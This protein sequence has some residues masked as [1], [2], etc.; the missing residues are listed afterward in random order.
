[1]ADLDLDNYDI[2]KGL[3]VNAVKCEPGRLME[4]VAMTAND[5]LFPDKGNFI[6]KLFDTYN[7]AVEDINVNELELEL[8]ITQTLDLCHS[9]LEDVRS[10]GAIC[11]IC[12]RKLNP[13][14]FLEIYTRQSIQYA[15][16]NAN[17]I[18]KIDRF[19]SVFLHTCRLY[20][21]RDESEELRME[22]LAIDLFCTTMYPRWTAEGCPAPL[23]CHWLLHL[24]LSLASLPLDE[25]EAI[26]LE[27]ALLKTVSQIHIDDIQQPNDTC[28]CNQFPKTFKRAAC[29]LDEL[30]CRFPQTKP[31]ISREIFGLMVTKGSFG[32]AGIVAVVCHFDCQTV[33][34]KLRWAADAPLSSYNLQHIKARHRRALT[35]LLR[36]MMEDP[37]EKVATLIDTYLD[38]MKNEQEAQGFIDIIKRTAR[39]HKTARKVSRC[40]R[41]PQTYNVEGIT[42]MYF[43]GQG[44]SSC[45][46]SH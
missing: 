35:R 28:T 6:K 10:L 12:W 30:M 41:L 32:S 16:S 17:D 44:R 27:E 43:T 4:F 39:S 14:N 1:M 15:P 45:N 46:L 9:N 5:T 21:M 8:L 11:I 2:R 23:S 34:R 37:N 42:T 26:C 33:L 24:E 31:K 40:V 25:D 18:S 7:D 13:R 38:W 36:W 29:L 3:S 20:V 19:L 22:K